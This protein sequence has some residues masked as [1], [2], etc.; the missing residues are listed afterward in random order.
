MTYV[1]LFLEGIITFISPCL[2]PLLPVYCTFFAAGKPDKRTALANAIGFVCGFTFVFVLLGAFAG[3]AGKFLIDYSV[4]V[5]IFSGIIIIF[6]GL[7]F[8]GIFKFRFFNFAARKTTHNSVLFGIIF[9]VCWSPCVGAF[10]GAALMKAAS[11]GGTFEGAVM[12][13][14]YSAGLGIPFVICAVLIDQLKGA[15]DFIKRN[16]KKINFA[17]GIFLVIMGIL[18][19]TGLWF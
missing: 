14:V 15:F 4:R 13:F 7:N 19:A 12:L 17:S 6:F 8:M 1:F 2:L 11:V 9:A 5:N 3:T 18:I 16:Y 10:L